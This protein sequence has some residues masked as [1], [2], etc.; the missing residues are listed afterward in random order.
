MGCDNE[1]EI[2][3]PRNQ[4]KEG[5]TSSRNG[6]IHGQLGEELTCP[7][8]KKIKT[9]LNSVRSATTLKNVHIEKFSECKYDTTLIDFLLYKEAK[10][11]C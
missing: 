11:K 6:R 5:G 3:F 2:K 8:L 4:K 10:K 1:T 9:M 7:L